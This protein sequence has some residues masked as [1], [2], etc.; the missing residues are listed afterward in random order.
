MNSKQEPLVLD[1]T[2]LPT[3]PQQLPNMNL[4]LYLN[5][6]SISWLTKS[7]TI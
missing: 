5:F 4:S 7:L 6:K 2:T 1:V 3:E